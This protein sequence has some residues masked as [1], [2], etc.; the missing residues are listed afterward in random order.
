MN[1]QPGAPARRR[2]VVGEA[3]L[4]RMWT[5]RPANYSQRFD[6]S[7]VDFG[8]FIDLVGNGR[9]RNAKECPSRSARLIFNIDL[10]LR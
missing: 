4:C 2:E 10:A 7:V 8:C 5:P 9:I 1:E 3:W 6:I